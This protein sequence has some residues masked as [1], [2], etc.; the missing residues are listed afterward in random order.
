VRAKGITMTKDHFD[1]VVSNVKKKL[2]LPEELVIKRD[3]VNKRITR[4]KL[5]LDVHES[6]G[7]PES[8]LS[9]VEPTFVE[10]ILMMSKIKEPLTP[11]EIKDFINSSIQG[12]EYQE[13][14]IEFK[15]RI[16]C[17]Q[18]EDQLGK[19][20]TR[21]VQAFLKRWDNLIH[22]KKAQRFE[23]D[24]GQWARYSNFSNMYD[25]IEKTLVAS[26]L[27]RKLHSPT[28]MNKEGQVVED[29]SEA[30]GRRCTI[31]ITHPDMCIAMD[32]V[33]SNTSQKGDGHVGGKKF[34]CGKDYI[35]R[36]KASKKEKHFTLL[37]LTT[38]TGSP[39]M[40]V[41]II[42]G[43][44]RIPEVETGIDTSVEEHVGSYDDIDFMKKNK[45]RG[46]TFPGGPICTFK[47]Q[48]IPCLVRFSESGG[49]TG[50][51]LLDIFKTLDYFEVFTEDRKNGRTPFVLLDGHD[52]RFYLP[53]VEYINKPETKFAV[54]LGVPYGTS[55]WQVGDSS[56]QNGCY[57]M[58]VTIAKDKIL[59][60]RESNMI[61]DIGIM[62]TDIMV[63]V[64][65]AWDKSF[66]RV[67][68]N[69]KAIAER[70]WF[71][72]NRILLDD[73]D[74][75][76]TMTEQQLKDEK[77]SSLSCDDSQ[78]ISELT[79][80]SAIKDTSYYSRHTTKP[81]SLNLGGAMG[82][83]IL[84]HIV[85]EVD[86]QNARERIENEKKE[87][88]RVKTMLKDIKRVTA[89]GIVRCGEYA[90]G[91]N[92]EDE[93]FDRVNK[94]QQAEDERLQRQAERE[95][96]QVLQRQLL[97]A[98]KRARQEQQSERVE[99]QQRLLEEKEKKCK[100][101]YLKRYNKAVKLIE[102]KDRVTWKISDYR[103]ALMALK[104]KDDGPLP[105]KLEE[106]SQCYDDWIERDV[107]LREIMMEQSYALSEV[108]GEDTVN[109]HDN[110]GRVVSDSSEV[111]SDGMACS[112]VSGEN[113]EQ[114]SL[115]LL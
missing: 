55:I 15:K 65:Q 42:Q 87:G 37:G 115:I 52:T 6:Q 74:L 24:R 57:K 25:S 36:L 78:D 47:G 46:K 99:K 114:L 45:G 28:W 31:E 104:T 35:P 34:I 64:N 26:G 51:I 22:S 61:S 62:P 96:N 4:K 53:F 60:Q 5:V 93:L 66:A 12:T 44:N 11:P 56:E 105:Q 30:Y 94:K 58:N 7:G 76:A 75:R 48:E 21:Y 81:V 8:P 32:E 72:Y 49:M 85:R 79:L 77:H 40:C 3:T 97:D 41:V 68:T 50:P 109:E 20:G 73:P 86:L 92:I 16:K 111:G 63:I 108:Q 67:H 29:C 13:K 23:L 80:D 27:A 112:G 101:Q 14:L 89:A 70:G 38:F 90:I 33:G 2:D 43:K 59:T 39:L 102:N 95:Q 1:E 98:K 10:I 91:K 88:V 18:D 69:K 54:S 106:L 9:E 83:H 113:S 71:P 110:S 103:V 84:T 107:T 19:V 100:E 82:Q 17:K